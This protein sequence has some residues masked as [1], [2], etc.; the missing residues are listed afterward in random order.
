[1]RHLRERVFSEFF[2]SVRRNMPRLV[3][4][5]A[6]KSGAQDVSRQVIAVFKRQNHGVPPLTRRDAVP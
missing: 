3:T 2:G 4:G 5:D 6:S 1:M